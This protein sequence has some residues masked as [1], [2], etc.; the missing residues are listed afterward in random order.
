MPYTIYPERREVTDETV[1]G[2]AKDSLCNQALKALDTG[3]GDANEAMGRDVVEATL[4][5]HEDMTLA[6]AV[7]ILEDE[8]SVTFGEPPR[9]FTGYGS[10]GFDIN[11]LPESAEVISDEAETIQQRLE[12]LRGELRAE[13]IS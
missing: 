2:W 9:T 3:N 8:G 5:N 12:Y 4:R 11:A 10:D 13:C 1:I 6:E 7:S